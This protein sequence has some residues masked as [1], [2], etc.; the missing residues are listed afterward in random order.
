[1]A[2]GPQFSILNCDS[3]IAIG[4]EKNCRLGLGDINLDFVDKPQKISLNFKVNG[5]A[6]GQDHCLAWDDQ[7]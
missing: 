6:I 4:K 5:I 7:G 2:A 1:M 3:L